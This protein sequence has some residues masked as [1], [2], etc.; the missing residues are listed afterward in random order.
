MTI[1]FLLALCIYTRLIRREIDQQL[2]VEVNKMV[3]NYVN[4]TEKSSS[5]VG[6]TYSKMDN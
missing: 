6:N 4:M 3:E 1:G 2:S 5:N